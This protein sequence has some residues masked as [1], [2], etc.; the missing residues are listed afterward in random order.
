MKKISSRYYESESSDDEDSNALNTTKDNP[1]ILWKDLQSAYQTIREESWN[2]FYLC[3][4]NNM[5]FDDFL[6]SVEKYR[7]YGQTRKDMNSHVQK[8]S[9]AHQDILHR[10]YPIVKAHLTFE[11]F[12]HLAYVRSPPCDCY[13]INK[14]VETDLGSDFLN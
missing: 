4:M 8:W 14:D 7:K 9:Y 10:L 3:F 11:N 1:D 13:N 2:M 5:S 6:R 12:V